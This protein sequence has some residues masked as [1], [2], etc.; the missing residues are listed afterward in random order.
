M[1]PGIAV[2]IGLLMLALLLVELT[3]KIA[4]NKWRFFKTQKSWLAISQR[5]GWTIMALL[6]LF[7]YIAGHSEPTYFYNKDGA[8]YNPPPDPLKLMV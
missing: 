3:C 6:L 4:G 7:V 5:V 8:P 2:S 1:P